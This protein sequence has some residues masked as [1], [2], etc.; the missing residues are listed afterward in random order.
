[1]KIFRLIFIVLLISFVEACSLGGG[2][3][4]RDHFYRIPEISFDRK[5]ESIY[6]S[7]VV[8]SVKA[9]GLYHERAILFI[10]KDKPLELQR[11]HYNFWSTTPAELIHEALIQA[12]QSSGIA[13]HVTRDITAYRPDYI[14]DTRIIHF[15]RLI[16]GSDVSVEV[17]LEISVRDGL[18]AAHHWT[19]R[20][21]SSQKLTSTDM[22]LSAEAFGKALQVINTEIVNDMLV[23]K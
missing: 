9:S 22:H 16:D 17:A 13:S 19:R 6:E 5:A 12:F 15:E 10:E 4:P 2:E 7:I 14:I 21:Q 11:Y 20:Y 8:K 18:K 23:K 3:A 1:M